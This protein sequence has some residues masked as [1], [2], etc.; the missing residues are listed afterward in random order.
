MHVWIEDTIHQHRISNQET[1]EN[2][3]MGVSFDGL[4]LKCDGSHTHGQCAGRETRATQLY[5]EEIVKCI[6]KGLKNRMLLNNAY[7]R[8]SQSSSL[9]NPKGPRTVQASPCIMMKNDDYYLGPDLLS[10]WIVKRCGVTVRFDVSELRFAVV[11]DPDHPRLSFREAMAEETA[12]VAKGLQIARTTITIL[13]SVVDRGQLG[14][15]PVGF[16][17]FAETS[18]T[19]RDSDMNRWMN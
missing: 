15:L 5:T 7:G 17:T 14:Q 4:H 1:M 2:H 3:F 12:T 6:I 18:T 13:R 9:R 16:R 10:N 11:T 8:S 19:C